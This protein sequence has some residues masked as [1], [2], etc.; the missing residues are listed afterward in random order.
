MT[1]EEYKILKPEHNHL[2][3]D[4]LWDAMADYMIRQQVGQDVMKS[5]VPFFKRY[6]LRWLLY[7]K[8]PNMRWGKN[9]Y[10]SDKRCKSCKRGTGGIKIGWV[11]NGVYSC[12]CPHCG[13]ELKEE[14]NINLNH[15]LWGIGKSISSYFWALL[16]KLH[17][18]RS[19]S[20]GRYDMFGDEQKYVSSYTLDMTNC[21]MTPRYKKRKWWE[22]IF[23]ERN[24]FNF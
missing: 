9:D 24:Q 3:G 23:I 8:I 16:D 17:L 10:S 12:S 18:V 4:D 7:R 6:Q 19:S 13:N 1:T 21:K 11:T 20:I 2:E 15:R 5:A 14:K 22:Y